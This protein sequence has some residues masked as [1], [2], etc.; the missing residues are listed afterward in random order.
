MELWW[1]SLG[2]ALRI[3]YAIAIATTFGLVLQMIAMLFGVGDE[4]DADF[5]GDDVDAGSHVLS[6]RTVTGFFTGFGWAGVAALEAGLALPVSVMIAAA[7]GVVFMAAVLGLM[8]MIYGLR[9]SGTL[10][11][12]NAVGQIGNVYLRVPAA[13]AGPG[14]VEVTVQGRLRVVQAFTNA[15]QDLTREARVKV[16][17]VMDLNTLVVEPLAAPTAASKGDS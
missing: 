15:G 16:V 12:R 5:D 10:D 1:S 9:Y 7:V 11:Y 2:T 14:Q 8:R 3:F 13:M 4:G 6:M 17:D